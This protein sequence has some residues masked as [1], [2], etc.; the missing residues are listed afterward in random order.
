MVHPEIGLEVVIDS[1]IIKNNEQPTK[2]TIIKKQENQSM[3]SQQAI[4]AKINA[5]YFRICI[6]FGA[7][8]L[9]WKTISEKTE[10]SQSFDNLFTKLP[11][12]TYFLIWCLALCI[13]VSLSILYILRCIFH[14][15]MVKAEY[16]H[17]IGVN[18]LFAPWV[19]WLLLLQSAPKF[20]FRNKYSYEYI[21]WPLIIPVIALDVKIYGQWFTTEK[22]FLSMVA[23][24]TSQ[25]SVIGNLVGSHA[26]I[27]MGWIESG[28]C[29]FTLGMT[30]YLVVF[31]TLYQRFTGNNHIPSRLRPVF[32]LF[33]ATPSM[34]ALAWK[35]ISGNFDILC[36]M[37]FFLSL[38]L[39]TSLASRP[40][41]FKKS[42]KNFSVAWW[43]FSFP[44]SFLAL[45]SM[46]YAHQAKDVTATSLALVLSA[47][48]VLVFV[49]LLVC[50]SLKIDSLLRKPILNFSNES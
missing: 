18:Y 39:F 31:I 37:L 42:V 24:P 19:S 43:A 44:L 38:F 20:I 35:S 32:F 5:S 16:H 7:Q 14:L 23:N 13:F 30:H 33:V 46:A 22:R 49:F 8:A 48:S 10:F 6:S 17:H 3:R 27:K 36:K 50:S 29:L 2:Q 1:S 28:I 11:S 40:V 9:L 47:I 15:N 21:W 4:I 26:A 45:A 25:M 41:M 34:A 12:T